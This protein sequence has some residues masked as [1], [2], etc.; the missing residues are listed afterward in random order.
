MAKSKY[1]PCKLFHNWSREV[2]VPYAHG[3]TTLVVC[4]DCAKVKPKGMNWRSKHE[5]T[6]AQLEQARIEIL[7]EGW[8][9]DGE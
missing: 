5:I 6:P 2:Y 7:G 3:S 9:T 1:K 8:E 4:E